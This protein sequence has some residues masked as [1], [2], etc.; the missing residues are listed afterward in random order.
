MM[1]INF[2][3]RIHICAL[4]TGS[5]WMV[6]C[7]VLYVFCYFLLTSRLWKPLDSHV[8]HLLIDS[9]HMFYQPLLAIQLEDFSPVELTA[10]NL[11]S[12]QLWEQQQQ[13][14]LYW[15]ILSIFK[16]LT[17]HPDRRLRAE[18]HC[19]QGRLFGLLSGSLMLIL[20]MR[21]V[22]LKM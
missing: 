4:S 17:A 12:S 22:V 10:Y 21:F 7:N 3:I 15:S 18:V 5:A 2:G 8:Y 16:I 13:G 14:S 19:C 11:P 9:L 6:V 1:R 20:R